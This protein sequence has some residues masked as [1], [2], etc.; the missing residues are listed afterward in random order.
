MAG[1]WLNKGNLIGELSEIV[2]YK[3]GLCVTYEDMK[4]YLVG[5][6]YLSLFETNL[7]NVV[8]IRP[9]EYESIYF[10]IIKGVGYIPM[11]MPNPTP[12]AWI[13]LSHKYKED[14]TKLDLVTK[15]YSLYKD[16]LMNEMKG[17]PPH[18]SID[19][20]NYV[21]MCK[22]K[23]GLSGSENALEILQIQAN[24]Q[25]TSPWN[26]VRRIIWENIVELKD[27]FKSESLQ[28]YYGSFIDQRYIDYLSNN[29]DDIGNIN[30]RK[31]EG[32]T[33]EYFERHGYYVK[34]GKGRN[35]GGIDAR[36]WKSKEDKENPPLVLIQCKRVKSKIEKVV[37]KALWADV[38]YE[39]AESG[40][41]VTCSEVA[42]GAKNDCTARGYNIKFSERETM[43]KWLEEMRTPYKGFIM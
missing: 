42:Q 3:A 27:L 17:L 6:D 37:V 14:K 28:T 13:E 18:S 22:D 4:K 31:F 43:K 19:P 21:K 8:R 5:T 39:G 38:F 36:I 32:L 25:E 40:L 2:G 11:E 10:S 16:W 29:F 34:I 41:I 20:T 23:Y 24:Y 15:V 1:I 33:C 12:H 30:W 26:K 35:D 7:H 9:D